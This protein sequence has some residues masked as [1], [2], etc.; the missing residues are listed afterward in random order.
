MLL[1]LPV[2]PLPLSTLL[3]EEE[4]EEDGKGASA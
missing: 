1:L 3:K 2:E 4:G